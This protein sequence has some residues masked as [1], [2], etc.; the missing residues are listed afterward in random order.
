MYTASLEELAVEEEGSLTIDIN[1]ADEE[2]LDELPQ[3]GP[4]TAEAIIEH[5]TANGRFDA[6]DELQE[7]SGIGP[8]TIRK[9]KPFAKV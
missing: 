7:V 2:E 8:K 3:V 5:R 4:A 9:I 6:V 1:T